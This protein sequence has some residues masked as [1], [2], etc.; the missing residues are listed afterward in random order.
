MAWVR[1]PAPGPDPDPDI[2]FLALD[3]TGRHHT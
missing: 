3:N 1:S 2:G